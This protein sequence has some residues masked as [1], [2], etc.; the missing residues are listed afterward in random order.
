MRVLLLLAALA[1]PV[2]AQITDI[3]GSDLI[4]N[5]RAVIN[6]NFSWLLQ[7]INNPYTATLDSGT[8]T[9]SFTTTR[10]FI[11][12]R[13]GESTSVSSGAAF[14]VQGP[15]GTGDAYIY[16]GG[17]GP[18]YIVSSADLTWGSG[19][20][21]GI[22]SDTAGEIP[23]CAIPIAKVTASS[24]NITAVTSLWNGRSAP[25]CEQEGDNI[26]IEYDGANKTTSAAA[27]GSS[28][29]APEVVKNKLDGTSTTSSGSTV[30]ETISLDPPSAGERYE[31]EA[32][33][34]HT[35]GTSHL[36]T[37][38]MRIGSTTVIDNNWAS[39]G[40]LVHT[41]RW[42]INI[43]S[44]TSQQHATYHIRANG[45]VGSVPVT[46]AFA[47]S[48]DTSAG[49]TLELRGLIANP[50]ETLTLTKYTVIRYPAV[51]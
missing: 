42:T 48:E 49:M 1:I 4:T 47:T 19:T 17:S 18:G 22:T 7:Q 14:S 24:D 6:T 16:F 15:T 43:L 20:L 41:Y 9:A 11:L 46:A 37:T 32:V 28:A 13:G 50:A 29:N 39:A 36:P 34:T 12:R 35:G 3:Q 8:D 38:S 5:S 31:I 33:Y 10:A 26:T 51:N 27:S 40:D 23:N 44:S 45:G 21:T 2:C 30:L 25:A